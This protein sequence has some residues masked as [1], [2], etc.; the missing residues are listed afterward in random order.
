MLPVAGGG[1]P[2]VV[3]VG[4]AVLLPAAAGVVV[5]VVLLM[6]AEA[7]AAADVVT[8]R[9]RRAENGGLDP[10][11][12]SFAFLGCPDFQSRGPKILILKG[13]GASGQKIGAPPKTRKSTTTDPTPHSRPSERSNCSEGNSCNAIQCSPLGEPLA[14]P[15]QPQ[16]PSSLPPLPRPCARIGTVCSGAGPI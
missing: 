7:G 2:A 14:P 13:F 15:S 11:W 8:S 1:S 3:E 10:S 9:I 12:L 4:L 6:S 16:L 5:V